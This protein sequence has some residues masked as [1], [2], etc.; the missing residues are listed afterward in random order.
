MLKTPRFGSEHL[1]SSGEIFG[2]KKEAVCFLNVVFCCIFVTKEEV[3]VNVAAIS[4][5]RPL[6]KIDMLE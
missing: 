3:L 1:P 5:F 2:F 4:E 6:S